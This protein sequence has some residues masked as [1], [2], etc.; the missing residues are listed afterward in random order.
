MIPDVKDN[1][2]NIGEQV[3]FIDRQKRMK[4]VII[5]IEISLDPAP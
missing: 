4:T 2:W 3:G 5:I 1:V